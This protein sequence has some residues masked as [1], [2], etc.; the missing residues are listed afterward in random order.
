V[1]GGAFGVENSIPGVLTS[2][3]VGALLM[4]WAYQK[5]QVVAPA[6]M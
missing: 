6:W 3:A 1:T 4:Y 5:K 2:V